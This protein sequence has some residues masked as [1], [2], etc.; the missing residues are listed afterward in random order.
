M[1]NNYPQQPGFEFLNKPQVQKH[2]AELNITLLKGTHII[3]SSPALFALLD[4]FEKDLAYYYS[5]LYGLMLE[6]RS[7]DNVTYFYLEFPK[8]GGRGRLT[9]PALYDEMDGKTTIVA[10]ILANLYFANYFSYDKKFQ[11]ED[12]QYEIEHGEH[13]EAYQ[14]LFFNENRADY[15]DKE[16]DNVQKLFA[17]VINYFNRIG[18]VEK[19][20]SEDS[21]YFSILPSI[22]H[23]IEIYQSEIENIDTFL[24][25]IKL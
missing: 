11:W 2:F 17:T 12:I 19:E 18:L 6:R 20:D 13:K 24:E 5:T 15:T 1:E 23:F 10:C 9:N 21:I 7:H 16:W 22:H 3:S 25:D 4:E 14:Q 8:A